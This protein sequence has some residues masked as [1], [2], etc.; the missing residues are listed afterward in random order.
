MDVSEKLKLLSGSDHWEIKAQCL[1][2]GCLMLKKLKGYSYLLKK[3]T[4]EG[5]QAKG[6]ISSNIGSGSHRGSVDEG[7]A[8]VEKLDRNYAKK[9]IEDNIEIIT[10]CFNINAPKSVQKLG[11]FV[12]QECLNDFKV[13]Y[14]E[15]IDTFL[16]TE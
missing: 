8:S 14:G 9:L 15:Y 7:A 6:A 2:F 16:Q 10:N 5:T 3:S 11:L 4:D 13:L 1:L 12:V